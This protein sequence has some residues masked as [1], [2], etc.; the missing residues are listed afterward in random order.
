[1]KSQGLAAPHPWGGGR[2]TTQETII[3][4]SSSGAIAN[5]SKKWGE[6]RWHI[7]NPLNTPGGKCVSVYTS[8]KCHTLNCKRNIMPIPNILSELDTNMDQYIGSCL[9]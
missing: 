3:G 4:V 1:M 6:M 7:F 9:K 5:L 2:L 8:L